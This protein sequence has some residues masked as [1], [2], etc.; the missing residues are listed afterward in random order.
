M[1][2]T[3]ATAV[4]GV[5]FWGV[6][7]HLFRTS[8]IGQASAELASMTLLAQVAQ[9]N[10]ANAFLRFVPQAGVRTRTVVL[11]GYAACGTLSILSVA[12]FLGTPLSSGIVGPELG[13]SVVFSIS[14]VLWTIFVVQDGALTALRAAGWVPV[15]NILFS[16]MKIAL[17]PALVLAAPTQG[18]FLAWTMPVVLAVL[19][20]NLFLFGRLIPARVR[21]TSASAPRLSFSPRSLFSFVA[22][23]YLAGLVSASSTFLLPLIV[24][25]RLG[26]TANAHFY[27]PWIVGI[28]FSNLLLNI[29]ASFIVEASHEEEQ[30]GPLFWRTARLMV[31]VTIVGLLLTLGAGPAILGLLAHS[32]ARTGTGLLRWI[33]LSFPFSI[34]TVLFT[35][36]LWIRRRLWLLVGYQLAQ[37]ALLI[38]LTLPLLG[39]FGISAPG[40]AHLVAIGLVGLC[41]V[42]GL[43]RWYRRCTREWTLRPAS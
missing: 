14:V 2:S 29:S 39:R 33:G 24:I 3:G 22:A 40:I 11:G 12:L 23:E 35:A 18:V 36:S 19:G 32:Y 21:S 42:P 17:L 16:A 28:A 7:A 20:V 43:L 37:T 41:S 4:L 31:G 15:E 25:T 1:L 34:L 5:V 26:A 38:G 8:A 9:L 30:F 10:L 27:L 6:A 13:F